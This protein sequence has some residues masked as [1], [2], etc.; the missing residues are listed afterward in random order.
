M[1]TLKKR[2]LKLGQRALD[3]LMADQRRAMQ[4]ARLVGG[5][6]KGKQALD[7]RQEDVMRALNFATRADLKAVG[8][9]LAS[10]KRRVRELDEKVETLSPT[11]AK[12]H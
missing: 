8:K 4:V 6:Q 7:R 10:L 3:S 1:K 11:V 5:A 2:A 9:K 12:G